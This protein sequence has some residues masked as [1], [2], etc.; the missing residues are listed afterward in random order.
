MKSNALKKICLAGTV[1]VTALVLPTQAEP[2]IGLT[3]SNQ[4]LTFDSATPATITKSVTVSGLAGAEFLVG[5]DL[6]RGTGRLYGLTN[7]SRLYLINSDTGDATAVGFSGAFTLSG[8]R[9]GVDFNPTVDRLRV[10][11]DADQNIRVNPIDGTLTG[12]DQTL[13]YPTADPHANANP[14]VVGLAYTN[15]F[16]TAGATILYGIDSGFDILVIQNP[17]NDGV[18]NT[19][20]ALGVDTTDNV[21]LDISGT[22]GIL[23]A[24]LNVGGTTGLYTINQLSGAATLVGTIADAGTLAGASVIDIAAGVPPSSRLL[25]ISTRGRVA[26]GEDVL[27]G[28][29]VTRTGVSSRY[30]LRALGPSLSGLGVTGPLADP[31][32]TL[33]DHNGAVITTNDNWLTGQSTEVSATG[34]APTNAAESAVIATLTPNSYT[35]IVSGKGGDAGVAVVE[36]Y[37]L[38]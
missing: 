20:G 7:M 6:R 2:I 38:P 24:S 25:N 27:I 14:N 31:V 21:G 30:L 26:P 23:Y 13:Q 33:Y 4:L 34:L 22:T 29:F 1:L 3:T 19:V 11:S 37:Q 36:I 17:P 12:T 10:T 15:N 5:I 9:F 28:G 35:A 8:T 16:S 32:L 18:L